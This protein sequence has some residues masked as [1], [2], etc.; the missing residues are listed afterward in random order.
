MPLR[1]YEEAEVRNAVTLPQ[2]IE[3]MESAFVT[4]SRKEATV[5]PVM[6]L[7][8]PEHR[9]E[10][11]MKCGYIHKAPY[12]VLKV[13]AGFYNNKE[14]GLP[15]S[16][17]MM[18]LFDSQTGFPVAALV[19]G[20]YLTDL[21]TAAAGAV[22][23]K[24]L[25]RAKVDQV[26]VIG[27]GAQG[28]FQLLA[29]SHVRRFARVRVYDHKPANVERYLRDMKPGIQADIAPA[30]T[31]EEAVRG[32]Q[33]VITATTTRQPLVR[34]DW[35]ESGTHITAM[36]SDDP[37]KQELDAEVLR[38]AD[39][40]VADSLSQCLRLGEIH[41]GVESGAIRE[42]DVAGELGEV[43][44]GKIPGRTSESQITICDLTGVGVQDAAIA[45]LAYRAL[46]I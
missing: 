35:V 2:A 39:L 31:V 5:P 4:Y 37:T 38:R 34:A 20:C 30:N 32:S 25:A 18:L 26:G 23:A 45:S 6:H 17:G 36:G 14:R 22:A 15:V 21:R 19:D 41:H 9:G 3:A 11:H 27:A 1:V 46:S 10:T 44:L 8:I 12:F 29:L 42:Q 28:R 7:D 24:Y 43:I 13:A 33:V 40:I 16:S